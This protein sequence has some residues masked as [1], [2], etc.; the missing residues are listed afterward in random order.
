MR[1]TTPAF[2][3]AFAWLALSQALAA[4]IRVGATVQVQPNS[5]W[6]EDTAK[7]TQWQRL[8]AGGNAAALA[9]YES[10]ALASREAWQFTGSLA[11][12]VLAHD[13][14]KKQVSVEMQTEGRLIG[15]KWVIDAGTLA[16]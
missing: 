13:P 3:I 4:D 5:I 16:P 14:A 2:L 6:F 8:K 9:S 11:V 12:K 7:L 10:K 15:T 1:I